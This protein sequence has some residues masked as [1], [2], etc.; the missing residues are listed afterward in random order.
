MSMLVSVSLTVLETSIFLY[1]ANSCTHLTHWSL[2]NSSGILI[3]DEV[4]VSNVSRFNNHHVSLGWS[5]DIFSMC[6]WF[7]KKRSL[8]GCWQCLFSWPHVGPCTLCKWCPSK[9]AGRVHYGKSSS[10]WVRWLK[11]IFFFFYRWSVLF[12]QMFPQRVLMVNT[13]KCWDSNLTSKYPITSCHRSFTIHFPLRSSLCMN[14]LLRYLA[15]VS[16]E[17]P[18]PADLKE[19][20]PESDPEPLLG[21]SVDPCPCADSVNYISAIWVHWD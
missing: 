3:C 16:P 1:G 15:E 8:N 6:T 2:N 9:L 4:H 19:P 20:D 12:F 14:H 18:H 7:G 5:T 13:Q 21:D 10:D 11:S 17:K